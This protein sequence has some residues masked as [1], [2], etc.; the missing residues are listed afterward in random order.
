VLPEAAPNP[1]GDYRVL[2]TA[3]DDV[4]GPAARSVLGSQ[5][6]VGA[7]TSPRLGRLLYEL[8]TTKGDHTGDDFARPLMPNM[9]RRVSLTL[10]GQLVHRERFLH[11]SLQHRAARRQ[12]RE[13]Y[14]EDRRAS[15]AGERLYRGVPDLQHHRRCLD[16][17]RRKLGIPWQELVPPEYTGDEGPLDHRTTITDD[18]NRGNE[19][20]IGGNWTPIDGDWLL[21]SNELEASQGSVSQ[22]QSVRYD[23]T[24]LSS[25]DH[26]AQ[27]DFVSGDSTSAYIGPVVRFSSSAETY[28]RSLIR[29]SGSLSYISKIVS[30]TN[31]HLATE[32]N[33]AGPPNT[34][35]LEVDGSILI[36][37]MNGG[38]VATVDDSSIS[39]GTRAGVSANTSVDEQGDNYEAADLALPGNSHYYRTQQGAA[40]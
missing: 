19:N 8:V 3:L 32:T 5:L 9:R 20:P 22:P 4:I 14:R 33:G 18:F 17:R 12:L 7:L 24:D 29:S 30:G 28:Y 36:L 11:S 40:A 6:G 31:T 25:V 1:G 26:Y 23:G 16:F 38:Q 35:Y 13:Q 27:L 15:L 10:A 21:V 39:T 37:K 34:G 2:G